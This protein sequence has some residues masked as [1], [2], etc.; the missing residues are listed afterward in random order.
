V[1][2]IYG[3]LMNFEMYIKWVINWALLPVSS[4]GGMWVEE[5]R[6]FAPS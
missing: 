6:C 3:F 1:N 2:N 4:F 5:C